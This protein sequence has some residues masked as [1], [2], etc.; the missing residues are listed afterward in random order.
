M[1]TTIRLTQRLPHIITFSVIVITFKIY[2]QSSNLKE[3]STVWLTVITML[4]IRLLEYQTLKQLELCTL[5]P[6][7]LHSSPHQVLAVMRLLATIFPKLQRSLMHTGL[8]VTP[9]DF[10]R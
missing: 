5:W 7:C 4:D 2:S 1:F 9:V 6:T 8:R 3:C 10:E